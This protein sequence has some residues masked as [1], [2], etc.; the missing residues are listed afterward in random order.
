[1]DSASARW[2]RRFPVA[3]FPQRLKA[4]A[5]PRAIV[6]I[7]EAM[8]DTNQTF[9][10]SLLNFTPMIDFRPRVTFTCDTNFCIFMCVQAGGDPIFP[11]LR[12]R[13]VLRAAHSFLCRR[14][15]DC[16]PVAERSFH[17]DRTFPAVS[18]RALR[19]KETCW[20]ADA[21]PSTNSGL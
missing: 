2:L 1:M 11:Y 14:V 17:P 5:V 9:F 19:S 15:P 8:P 20:R 16:A 18:L 21:L 12:R 10:N 6:A 13:S 7:A 4:P 3:I